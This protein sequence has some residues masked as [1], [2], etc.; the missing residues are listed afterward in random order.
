VKAL[1]GIESCAER[2]DACVHEVALAVRAHAPTLLAELLMF[3]HPP[4]A[5]VDDDGNTPLHYVAR[6]DPGLVEAGV[7]GGR[8]GVAAVLPREEQPR[9]VA[10][11]HAIT[12]G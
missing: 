3:E 7:P 12:R 1:G 4:T 6:Y 5:A 11:G 10:G 2:M 8:R 9:A